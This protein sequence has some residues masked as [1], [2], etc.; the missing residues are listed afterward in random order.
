MVI[1]VIY[2]HHL[3][4]GR[5]MLEVEFSICEDEDGCQDHIVELPGLRYFQPLH[6]LLALPRGAMH[7]IATFAMGY[8]LLW[9]TKSVTTGAAS[10]SRSAA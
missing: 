1:E 10:L 3:D 9:R 2:S 4:E 8:E 6:C 7:E 5:G